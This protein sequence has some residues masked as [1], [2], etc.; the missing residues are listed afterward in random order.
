[1]RQTYSVL[2]HFSQVRLFV[3]LWTELP[4]F[5]CPWNSPGKNTGVGC[6]SLLQEIFLIQGLNLCLLHCRQ[7]VDRETPIRYTCAEVYGYIYVCIWLPIKNYLMI[8]VAE[9][10]ESQW[11]CCENWRANDLS[12]RQDKRNLRSQLKQ[13]ENSNSSSYLFVVFRPSSRLD[14]VY[15]SWRR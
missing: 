10:Q 1:M 9:T 15:P 7:I 2:S 8:I 4:R 14:D 13:A 5:L 6:H 3:T 12:P 11:W